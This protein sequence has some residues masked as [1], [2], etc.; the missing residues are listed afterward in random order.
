MS[1]R[2]Y[3]RPTSAPD[4]T[5]AQA[6]Q[7]FD[8]VL[9]DASGENQGRGNRDTREQ[10]EQTLARNDLDTVRLIGLI[11]GDEA[12]FCFADIPARQARF[13]RQALP[14]A[15]EEQ[16]AQDIDGVHLALGQHRDNGF[17][18]AA[19]DHQRMAHWVGL[20][21][22]WDGAQ[23]D[24]IYPDAILLP[25]N[26]QDWAICLDGDLALLA[27]TR[28]EWLR[29]RIDNLN[30]FAQT[31]A[32]P[33]ED[34]VVAEVRVRVFGTREDFDR[35][36][37]LWEQL[38]ESP[39]LSFSQ[40][41]LEVTPLELLAQSH[42]QHLCEPINLCQGSYSP[43]AD[44]GGAW[45]PW[46]PAIAVACLW[47]LLLTG[48][49]VGLGY[50]HEQQA[51]ALEQQAMAIYRSAFPDD[52]RTHSG[53]VR[54]VV[55][56]QLRQLRE[57]GSDAGFLALMQQAGQQYSKVDGNSGTLRFNSVN[58]SRSRGEL[59]VDVRADSYDKLNALRTG[60]TQQGLEASIGSVVNDSDGARGRLTVSGG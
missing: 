7:L 53:N 3:V 9:T 42:H 4:K 44:Q 50:Y 15:V 23:L 13:V 48:S 40:Q 14:F 21:S 52:S 12:I 49:Q 37:R 5:D 26:E 20:F 35:N 60:I 41:I 32:L 25:L 43:S 28:G 34:E 18:V 55:E 36:P 16:L 19:I 45:R 39:R 31:L 58:Y 8:W 56:G 46:K 10:V 22:D 54:R 33:P 29:M 30:I 57:G 47:F 11:P 6:S 59:I 1:Y 38:R 17:H 27:S 51:T 24:A 2:L